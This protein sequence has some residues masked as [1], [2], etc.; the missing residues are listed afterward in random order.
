MRTYPTYLEKWAPY[1]YLDAAWAQ[2]VYRKG[3]VDDFIDEQR[4]LGQAA[5]PRASWSG[6][7]VLKGGP[8]KRQMT[9]EPGEVA[10]AASS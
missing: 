5:G 2:Y 10:G 7:N 1:R 6:L 8:D 3:D 9:A 4:R